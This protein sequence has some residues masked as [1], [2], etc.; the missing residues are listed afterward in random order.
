MEANIEGDPELVTFTSQGTGQEELG[1]IGVQLMQRVLFGP[2]IEGQAAPELEL[3]RRMQLM[4]DE[5][6]WVMMPYRLDV[7]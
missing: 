7:Q 5:K 6:V 3:L 2:G 4:G 1:R